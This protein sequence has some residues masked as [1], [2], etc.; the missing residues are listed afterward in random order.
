MISAFV[1]AHTVRNVTNRFPRFFCRSKS[2]EACISYEE[3]TN[4]T[5]NSD[6]PTLSEN[7]YKKEKR[8]CILCKLKIEPDYKNA[9]LLS[10]F[11]SSYTG[12]IYGKHITGLCDRKQKRVE[13]EIV[14]AQN[15]GLMG[16]MTKEPKY[17]NDPKLFNP[18]FPFKPH[19]Y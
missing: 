12:R 10:Q 4:L 7:P 19:P 17:V 2:T 9:R 5:T 8:L 13:E 16:Y 11:Q 14:K 6:L 1:N 15:A 18:A 3:T